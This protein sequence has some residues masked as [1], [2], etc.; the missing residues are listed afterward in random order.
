[1]HPPGAPLAIPARL[2]FTRASWHPP[3]RAA[4]AAPHGGHAVPSGGAAGITV[5]GDLGSTSTFR[6]DVLLSLSGRAPSARTL[7]PVD[8]KYKRYDRYGVGAGDVHQLVPRDD[9]KELWPLAAQ[10]G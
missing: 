4:A 1:M 5:R 9:T 7:L 6:P 8:A 10:R 2:I 3:R